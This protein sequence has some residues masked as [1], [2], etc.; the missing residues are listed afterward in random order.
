MDHLLNFQ[1]CEDDVNSLT[2]L[3]VQL[4]GKIPNA[5]P[6]KDIV[7]QQVEE[8]I[9]KSKE[10]LTKQ[11]DVKAKKENEIIEDTSVAKLFEEVKLMFKD[12]PSKIE[13]RIE[14]EYRRRRR[15][16]HP[17]MFDEI[18]HIGM[19]TG[20][21][22]IGFLMMIS[23]FKDEMPWIYEMG[24]DT[25]RELKIAKTHIERKKL[26][27]SFIHAFDLIRHPMMRELYGKSEDMIM[28]HE[29][30]LHFMPLFLDKYLTM[31]K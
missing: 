11:P 24:L 10:I 30:M 20:N 31:K 28:L 2:K 4:V 27:E 17:M 23:F 1:N 16:F 29:D 7:K 18:L 21:I 14:P 9:K 13:N 15:K 22:D 26:M 8:F 12:L 19:K 25:Y 5:D 3:V 6:D